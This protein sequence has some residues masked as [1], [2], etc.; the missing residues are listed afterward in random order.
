[1]NF[2][3]ITRELNKP[4]AMLPSLHQHLAHAF[5][6][7]ISN[8]REPGRDICGDAV[9]RKGLEIDQDGHARIPVSGVLARNLSPLMRSGATDYNEIQSEIREAVEEG[10]QSIT[11]EIDSGGGSSSGL[12]ETGKAIAAA[13][14]PTFALVMGDAYSAAYWLASQCDKIVGG[15]SSGFGSIGAYLPPFWD[16]SEALNNQGIKIRF[17]FAGEHKAAGAFLEVPMTDQQ[18]SEIQESLE[19][20]H[21]L[22]KATVSSK[23]PQ[24]KEEHMEAQI[25]TGEE[26]LILGFFDIMIDSVMEFEPQSF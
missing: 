23:R 3:R 1:M 14:V 17:A 16:I 8:L 2:E 12:I 20:L 13:P 26:A 7:D 24:I 18:F 9:E 6:T 11:L 15:P 19:K 10:A 22:F 5:L 25:Y 4:Q 21:A